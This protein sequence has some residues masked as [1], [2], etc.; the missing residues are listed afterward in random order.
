MK[1]EALREISLQSKYTLTDEAVLINGNQALVRMLL[2]RRELDERAGLDTAGFVT[3]YR[4]SPIGGFDAELW[5]SRELLDS[6]NIR[7]QP[8]VNEDLAATAITGT[9][10]LDALPNPQVEG[11]FSIWYGKGPGVDRS[12]DALKHGNYSG[13]H[14]NG[15]VLVV[16]GDDHPGKSSTI[17]NQSEPALAAI[18][19]PSL[20]PANV[21]EFIEFGLKGWAMSR[22][23]GL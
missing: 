6:H 2:L 3:G 23:T 8:G 21:G 13:A 15:G 10:Q 17:G 9:Q 1:P 14:R 19:I 16:Y 20:Y 7:F 4:G 22:Y 11:V 18:A 5:R 12:L